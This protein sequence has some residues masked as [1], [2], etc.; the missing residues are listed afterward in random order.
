MPL[1][2]LCEVL[3]CQLRIL[4]QLRDLLIRDIDLHPRDDIP[5]FHVIAIIYHQ[6]GDG[7]VRLRL[8]TDH[9]AGDLRVIDRKP[10][11]AVL[12]RPDTKRAEDC[13]GYECHRAEL[14]HFLDFICNIDFQNGNLL[15][16]REK[17]LP[18]REDF[19]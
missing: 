5:C 2:D 16:V 8:D 4:F 7:P 17:A 18:I 3:L 10:F 13:K 14:E 12:I 6:F 9:R 15:L 19:L 1:L 11:L